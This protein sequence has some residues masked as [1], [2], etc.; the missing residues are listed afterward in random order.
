MRT[1]V[2]AL[3]VM[4]AISGLAFMGCDNGT[5]SGGNDPTQG[6][7]IAPEFRGTFARSVQ[8]RTFTENTVVTSEP[9]FET[10]TLPGWTVGNFLYEP[11]GR[12]GVF[13]TVDTFH[14]ISHPT[15]LWT[16]VGVGD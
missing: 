13:P 7:V 5:T 10:Y 9:G 6:R 4:M 11:G 8:T 2:K 16:R 14:T 15:L 1:L 3:I 12:W